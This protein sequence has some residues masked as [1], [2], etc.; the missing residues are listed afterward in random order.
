MN[1]YLLALAIA[2]T[3]GL[4]TFVPVLAVRWP[5]MNWTT[6]GA[7]VLA[8]GEL[9]ADKVPGVPG[10]T[11]IGPLALRAASGAFCAW[12]VG[13]PLGLNAT[14][15]ICIG[16]AGAIAG[17]YIGFGWRVRLAPAIKL[18]SIVA[19]LFEDVVAIAVAFWLVLGAH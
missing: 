1:A 4:R 5:Y 12:A 15:A 10:R 18:P 14:A 3:A 16:I 6:W 7:A 13:T 19:A 2:M 8:A 11:S 17:A 9:I